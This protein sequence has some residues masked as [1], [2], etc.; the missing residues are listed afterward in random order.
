MNFNPTDIIVVW[1]EIFLLIMACIVLLLDIYAKKEGQSISYIMTQLTLVVTA[2][3]VLFQYDN[4]AQIVFNGAY[5]RDIMSDILKFSLCLAGLFVFVY[6]RPYLQ[7]IKMDK[8]EYYSLGLFAILG[9]MIMSSAHNFLTIY[10]GLELLSLSL[11]AMVAYHKESKAANEAAMKYFVLGALASGLLL[12]GMSMIYGIT[13][14]LDLNDIDQTLKMIDK[15]NIILTFGLVFI[16]TGIAFKL[17]AV[18]FHMWLPDVYQGSPAPVTLFVG[19]LP[20]IAAFAL[21]TRILMNGLLEL[22]D[23]WEGM[24]II[25]CILSLAIGNIVA[26]AQTNIKRML[27]YSTISHVGFLM[28]GVI[29]GSREGFS[30]AMFYTLVYALMATGTFGI[31]VIMSKMGFEAEKLEDYKGLYKKSP[32]LSLMMM[33][34]MFSMAGVPPTVGFYAKLSVL[35]AVV[36]HDL[37]WLAV[38]A[39]FFSVIGAFYYLRIIKLMF[40]DEPSNDEKIITPIHSKV[41]ISINGLSVLGLGIYPTALLVLCNKAF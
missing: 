21:I 16:V 34:L 14:S 28:L 40:F 31:V 38:V 27:A 35:S 26:I 36:S 2:L 37:V 7:T 9:M 33:I 1:P 19:S 10:L 25:L 11:Y 29:A 24:L 8:S 39:V 12:Y 32:L 13:G 18:P 15:Q 22:S 23:Q 20:K 5:I 3:I 17:G 6:S 41:A 30:A 4:H